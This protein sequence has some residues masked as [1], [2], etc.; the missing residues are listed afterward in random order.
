MIRQLK[1]FVAVAQE[2]TFAG[3]GQKIGLTQAAV[4]AQ[5]QR[6]EEHLGYS[7]FDRTGRSAQLNRQGQEA[8]MQAQELVRLYEEMGDRRRRAEQPGGS[9]AIGAIASVQTTVLT[10]VL[11]DFHR[12]HGNYRSHIVP[13]VSFG[14][15][16]LVDA[17]DLDMA[18]LIRPAFAL[19][20]DLRWTTLSHEPFRLLVPQACSE[21]DWRQALETLPFIRYDRSSFG[22]RL[23][24]RFLRDA[25]LTV[26]E[27]IE[28]DEIDAM[29]ELVARG[30]GAALV[31]QTH[32]RTNWPAGVRAI[33]LGP[34]TFYRDIGLLQR[35][36]RL[37][38][39]PVH[40]F[41]RM[42]EQAFGRQAPPAA[43]D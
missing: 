2:G 3:A 20:A 11:A 15:L 22:G 1:T 33:D 36:S 26:R 23:V 39:A 6:L 7:L 17:G 40:D 32:S 9:V 30:V 4:S 27:C 38:P 24:E 21:P 41:V 12:R 42:V 14:L 25:R 8:L 18:I 31:P 10:G 37:Q 34:R 29:I 28:I 13:G 19:Q 16:N 35:A 5:I 43:P